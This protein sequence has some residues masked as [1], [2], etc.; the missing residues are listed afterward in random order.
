M[1]FLLL[2]MLH[3]GVTFPEQPGGRAPAPGRLALV[4]EFV[5]THDI[6]D[7]R[8]RLA[9]PEPA[10]VWL[11]ERG[12]LAPDET[13]SDADFVW[14]LDVRDAL[15]ALALANNGL[16]LDEGAVALLN[17]AAART[18]TIHFE[19]GGAALRP[20]GAGV[21]RAVGSLLAVV[22]DAIHDGTWTRMKACRREVCRW[23]FYDHSRNRGSSWCAMAICGNRTKTRAYRRRRKEA[24]AGER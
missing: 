16:P 18:L 9:R 6:E 4:Q 5:N 1:V 2:D 20:A 22:V 10:R 21:Q 14:L 12:L 11:R 19:G 3:A 17:E 15:R 8:D 24:R 23:L 13:V 7:R